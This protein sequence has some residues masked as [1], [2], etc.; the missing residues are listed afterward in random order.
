MIKTVADLLKAFIDE[1]KEKLDSY[2]LTHGPTIG[3]M[4]EGLTKDVINKSIPPELS[5]QVVSGFAHHKDQLSG[6]IDCM[7]VKG[8]G[9]AI[10]FTTKFKWPVSDVI[11]VFEVKKSLNAEEIEDSFN[12]LRQVSQ[13]YSEYLHSDEANASFNLEWP[14]KVF[15]QLTGVIPPSHHDAHNLS[16]DLEMIYHTLVTEFCGPIRVL[17]GHHGWKKEKT[18]RDHIYKLLLARMKNPAGMGVGSFPQLMIAGNHSIVKANGFPYVPHM[19]KGM[20]MFL[21]STSHNPIRLLLELIFTKL[22]GLYGTD[23]TFDDSSDAEAMS[24]CLLTRAIKKESSVGW[25]YQYLE[26]SEKDLQSRGGTYKWEPAELS[27]AQA[28]IIHRLCAGEEVS[29]KSQSFVELAAN[30]QGGFDAFLKSLTDTQLL[31]LKD[32]LLVLITQ[33]CQVVIMPDGKIRA[34]ENNCNQMSQWIA[35]YQRT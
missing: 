24:P 19:H 8:V 7:L 3:A 10:P 15:A 13:L 22:D 35:N 33:K 29:I 6:E 20:W 11:A 5:L 27:D 34:G 1:E 9:E 26:F 2:N 16:F 30:A 23:L 12:H 17:V 14:R 18:F 4:Y 25:E 21:N 32:D 28:V 31:A